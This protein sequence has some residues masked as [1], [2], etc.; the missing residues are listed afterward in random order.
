MGIREAETVE[1]SSPARRRRS[2]FPRVLGVVV[3]VGILGAAAVAFVPGLRRRLADFGTPPITVTIESTPSG[4][5]V[6]VDEDSLGTT[7]AETRLAPG[8]H[9]VRIVHLGY[10]P[11]R[12]TFDPAETHT[13]APTLEPMALA[14]LTVES[15]PAGADVSL[16]GA[17]RGAAPVTL[18]HVEPGAH[19]VRVTDE[20]LYEAQSQG[21]ELG[22]GET[23]R[24]V[25]T[26]TSRIEALYRAQ[27][28]EEPARLAHRTELLHHLLEER[29]L[30]KAMAATAQALQILDR[31]EVSP[32]ELLQFHAELDRVASMPGPGEAEDVQKELLAAARGAFGRLASKEPHEPARY[33]PV[34]GLLGKIG[35]FASVVEACDWIVGAGPA[36][37]VVHVPVAEGYLARGLL[38]PATTLLEHA[39]KLRADDFEARIRLGAAYHRGERDDDALREYGAAEKLAAE[40][41]A[42]GQVRLQTEIARLLAHKGDMDGAVARYEKAL[43]I[44]AGKGVELATGLVAHYPFDKGAA[45]ASGK[46]HHGEIHGAAQ[47]AEGKLAGAL[48]FDGQDDYVGI[49]VG[50]TQGLKTVSFA[51]WLKT[52]QVGPKTASFWANPTLLGTATGG[53]GS[54]D[55]GLTLAGGKVAYFHGLTPDET[56]RA[57][58]SE[59]AANDGKWHH[60]AW[61]NAGPL[62]LVY[63]DG[64]LTRGKAIRMGGGTSSLGE[65]FDTSSGGSVGDSYL[66]IGASHSTFGRGQASCFYR[67]LIDDVRIWNRALSAREIATLCGRDK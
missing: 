11:W 20:P 27:I 53:Y 66:A 25:V 40:A 3:V 57:W 29:A 5:D 51:L 39:T 55:L 32:Q 14:T 45:D 63:V 1:V 48:S 46:G 54:G 17:R 38:E 23:R 41:P 43:G 50:A 65:V 64:R 7:P 16:D 61:V 52:T 49:P 67:G 4:A 12:H 13:L 59:V 22:A 24:L 26:L 2:R 58:T 19:Q 6:F 33:L 56:D 62:V 37:V 21:V 8:Q 30:A 36:A 31:A 28:E 60:F 10:K 18:G 44:G 9:V 34:V 15:E 47:V 42:E 35:G